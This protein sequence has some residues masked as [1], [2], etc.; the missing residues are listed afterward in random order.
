[1]A[2]MSS[3]N[4]ASEFRCASRKTPPASAATHHSANEAPPRRAT[5]LRTIRRAPLRWRRCLPRPAARACDISQGQAHFLHTSRCW[6]WEMSER[7][8]TSNFSQANGLVQAAEA[9]AL[10][11][12]RDELIADLLERAD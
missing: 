9:I 12:E 7:D 2:S 1:M 8:L 10:E 11:I 4:Q 3:R 5:S 6:P